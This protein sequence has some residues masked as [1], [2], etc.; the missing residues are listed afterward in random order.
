MAA[1]QIRSRIVRVFLN[2]DLPGPRDLVV[3]CVTVACGTFER[4]LT[5]EERLDVPERIDLGGTCI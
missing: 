1:Q 5:W 2:E 4:V 3:I